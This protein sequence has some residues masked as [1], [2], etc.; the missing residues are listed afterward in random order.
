MGFGMAGLDVAALRRDRGR[1]VELFFM[2]LLRK[3][4]VEGAIQLVSSDL[5][6]VLS[7]DRMPEMKRLGRPLKELAKHK[8]GQELIVKV[9]EPPRITPRAIV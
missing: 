5:G 6:W 9:A 2:A 7:L 3:P 8:L 1:A 4:M